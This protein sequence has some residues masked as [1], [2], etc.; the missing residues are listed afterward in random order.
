MHCLLL[1]G[2]LAV[3]LIT[4]A[5]AGA[6]AQTAQQD[7]NPFGQPRPLL[8]AP[9]PENADELFRRK[10]RDQRVA[11]PEAGTSIAP[12][13]SIYP[14]PPPNAAPPSGVV[15]APPSLEARQPPKK[16]RALEGQQARLNRGYY[17]NNLLMQQ[18]GERY[19]SARDPGVE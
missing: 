9:T 6:Q 1:R 4:L 11:R 14:P 10:Q 12:P 13:R 15:L 18:R 8:T 19:K 16:T 17:N 5:A 3:A 2:A 7:R